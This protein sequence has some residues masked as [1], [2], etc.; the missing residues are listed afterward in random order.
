MNYRNGRMLALSW[1]NLLLWF[2][3]LSVVTFDGQ[4]SQRGRVAV[5]VGVGFAALMQH[6]AYYSQN[7]YP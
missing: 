1:I 2:S 6:Q 3:A 7:R 5:W 4:V